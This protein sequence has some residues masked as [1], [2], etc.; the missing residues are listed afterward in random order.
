MRRLP[1]FFVIDCSESMVGQPLDA[2][3]QG[4]EMMMS[5]LRSDPYA[6]E[7]VYISVIAYAGIVRTL[8]PLTE[9]FAYRPCELPLG[10][11]THLGKALTHLGKEIDR[12][13]M[14]TTAEVKG[15]WKPIVY[16]FSDGRPTD[17][18]ATA[19]EDWNKNYA[20]KVTLIALGLG[21]DVDFNILKKMT[22]HCINLID[23]DQD[24]IKA[25]FK[26]ISAAVVSQSI[27]VAQQQNQ[28]ELL[29]VDERYMQ[30]AK[31]KLSFR[32]SQ[33]DD[34]SVTFVGR[35]Q[36]QHSPYILKYS[37]TL[38]YG[39]LSDLNIN[40][41]KFK[42]ETCAAISEDYFSWS[43]QSAEKAKIN[44]SVLE[45][46]SN[47]PHCY[48]ETAFAL[49]SCGNLTCYDGYS[50]WVTCPWC[51]RPIQFSASGGDFDLTRGQG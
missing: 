4:I 7:T 33:A 1:V 40:V 19:I 30:L 44:T 16:L 11:G 45:G 3:Q 10:G 24:Y 17:D 18:Y 35:C 46:W 15:D 23:V 48:A 20:D 50:E 28:Q 13:V 27:S 5:T 26:W 2:V 41:Y 21:Q 36:K 25:L 14:R 49:C 12:S 31:Q 22:P 6:L 32:K 8:V 29:P 51:Q 37:R 39:A 34:R 9:I 43:D 38:H 47:C 42:L